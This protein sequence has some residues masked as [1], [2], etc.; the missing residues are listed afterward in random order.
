[1]LS[2]QRDLC[3]KKAL[4]AKGI[5]AKDP[6]IPVTDNFLCTGGEREHIACTGMFPVH[7]AHLHL[8]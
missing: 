7:T 5:K 4:E 8:Q 6:K 2:T 1:M 3:I